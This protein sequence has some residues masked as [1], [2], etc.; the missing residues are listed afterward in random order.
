MIPKK[1]GISTE[2]A[3]LSTESATKERA[4]DSALSTTTYDDVTG[5]SVARILS[6]AII[7]RTRKLCR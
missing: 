1:R 4:T 7:V 3:S 6:R 5:Y 2:S